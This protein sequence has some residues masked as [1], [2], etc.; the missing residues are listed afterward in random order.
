M[1]KNLLAIVFII[2]NGLLLIVGYNYLKNQTTPEPETVKLFDPSEKHIDLEITSLKD[3]LAENK[4]E[5]DAIW[6]EQKKEIENL[7]KQL[8]TA[9]EK[10][11]LLGTINN[12][13]VFVSKYNQGS[14]SLV[15][16]NA[17]WTLN[18]AFKNV[19]PSAE[20]EK[21]LPQK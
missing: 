19:K 18:K 1:Q 12:E 11:V 8:Q 4:Q 17:D 3:A 20:V 6:Y 7:K 21:F 5:L 14:S 9:N 16:L 10:I 2:M 15:F 13:N